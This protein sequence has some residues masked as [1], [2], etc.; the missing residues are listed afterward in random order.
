MKKRKVFCCVFTK[1]SIIPLRGSDTGVQYVQWNRTG[2]LTLCKDH[3]QLI[4]FMFRLSPFLITLERLGEILCKV[5]KIF[6]IIY[7][8]DFV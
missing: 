7:R 1:S 3:M 4:L 8:R 6:P 2:A 5:R